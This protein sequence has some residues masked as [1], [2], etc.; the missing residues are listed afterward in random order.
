[1]LKLLRV[2][3]SMRT[4]RELRLILNAILSC[5]KSMFWATLLIMGVSFMFGLCFL[6][7]THDYLREQ[8]DRVDESQKEELLNYRGG[9]ASSVYTL[10][11]VALGGVEWA[12]QAQSL[13]PVGYVFFLLFLLYVGFFFC[14]ITNPLTS[15]FVE[16]TMV[17]A[18]KDQQQVI[19]AVLEQKVYVHH[20]KNLF[21]RI[22]GQ[23]PAEVTLGDFMAHIDE[24]EVLLFA[25]TLGIDMIDLKQL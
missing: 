11:A 15:L 2:I 21:V 10:Y 22:G 17:N 7:A 5:M 8:G 4:F 9:V 13:R 6:T 24:A 1:M 20:L 18:E 12:A 19:Q 23:P 3:R 25:R 16:A 14:G